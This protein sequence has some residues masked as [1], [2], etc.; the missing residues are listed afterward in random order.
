[1]AADPSQMLLQ[2]HLIMAVARFVPTREQQIA[3]SG[4][5]GPTNGTA[6]V[7][8]PMHFQLAAVLA[9][10]HA[11]FPHVAIR[12]GVH[13]VPSVTVRFL[14]PRATMERLRLLA[15]SPL[16]GAA[17]ASP[18]AQQPQ[19]QSQQQ[20]QQMA[21]LRIAESFL[22]CMMQ[23]YADRVMHIVSVQR[24][25]VS[26]TGGTTQLPPVNTEGSA[27][28]RNPRIALF[29]DTTAHPSRPAAFGAPTSPHGVA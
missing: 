7:I 5:G 20:Q 12:K 11:R 23:K 21:P 17:A 1:L 2:S 15:T 10:A 6:S 22:L 13:E 25:I 16:D 8:L 29:G 9:F 3:A 4:D 14:A 27:F 26:I 19:P 18:F 24:Q 28:W